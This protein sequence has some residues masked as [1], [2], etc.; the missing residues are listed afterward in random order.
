M[1]V[2]PG[3][4]LVTLERCNWNTD[5]VPPHTHVI[6][7]P[8]FC[9][10]VSPVAS[11]RFNSVLRCLETDAAL[12]V[13]MDEID[14]LY[15]GRSARFHLYPHRHGQGV[16]RHLERIGFA[17]ALEYDARMIQS[18]SVATPRP[19]GGVRFVS[20]DSLDTL[21][22]AETVITRVFDRERAPP[23]LVELEHH[24]KEICAGK[25]HQWVGYDEENGR[26]VAQAGV[27]VYD[28]LGIG[29]LFGGSTLETHRGRGIYRALIEIRA[30]VC[31]RRS[32]PLMGLWAD[33]MT[34]SPITA[35]HGFARCGTMM[36]W[37]RAAGYGQSTG[38][39]D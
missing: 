34:S 16:R 18:A 6:E 36:R 9:A 29:L 5:W 1:R 15:A 14:T 10:L 20:V 26:P 17:P 21:R 35:R 24:L 32:L 23:S 25:I 39:Q 8:V 30:A 11:A 4:A 13:R 31:R 27:A 28:A 22:D 38:G 12:E 37:T 33:Q 2:I 19:V 3:Q 7:N